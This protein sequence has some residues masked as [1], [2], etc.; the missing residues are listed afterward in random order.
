MSKR[1]E[2]C[3]PGSERALLKKLVS[4]GTEKARVI[5]RANILLL[6]D[7]GLRRPEVVRV[8]GAGVATVGRVKR[9]YRTEGL[10][11]ALY[12]QTR[13]GRPVTYGCRAK[14]KIVALACSQPPDGRVKWTLKLLAEHSS[15]S[16]TPSKNTVSLI[17]R[18]DGIKPWRKKNVV[19]SGPR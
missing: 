1:Y 5:R 13:S 18:E 19:R 2:M 10:D 14:K 9:S 15:L 6:L 17:L 12:E 16:P 4:V 8:T 3:L 11:G 7:Q